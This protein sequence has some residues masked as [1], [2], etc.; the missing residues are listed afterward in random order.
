MSHQTMGP[1]TMGH[2]WNL[3]NSLSAKIQLIFENMWH[4][5]SFNIN[6]YFL[7]EK[8]MKLF[9]LPHPY[10]VFLPDFILESLKN[11]GFKF[12]Y[13]GNDYNSLIRCVKEDIDKWITKNE[14]DFYHNQTLFY[15]MVNSTELEHHLILEKII[16]NEI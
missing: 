10:I 16:K 1:E 11:Y 15:N 3:V 7:T 9:L 4:M 8:T 6:R 13:S 2:A 14:S 5:Q 12:S